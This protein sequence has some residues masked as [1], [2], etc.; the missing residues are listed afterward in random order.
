MNSRVS[1]TTLPILACLA[2]CGGTSPSNSSNPPGQTPAQAKSELA[3][4]P[5][6]AVPQADLQAAVAANNAFAVDLY[7]HVLKTA[8]AGNLFTSPISASL[9]LT[10]TY[11]GAKGQTASQMA[12][13]LH[14]GSATSTTFA[15]QNALDQALESRA[16]AALASDTQTAKNNQEPAPSASDYDLHVVNSVWGEQNYPWA[17][18]FL[19]VMATD[20]GAGVYLEDFVHAADQARQTINGWVSTQTADRI[21]NLL[22]P[23]SVDDTTRMVL[24]NAIHLKLPWASPFQASQTQNASFTRADG[25]TVSVPMMNQGFEGAGYADDGKAQILSVPLAGGAE[26]VIIALPHGDLASY[27]AQLSAGSAAL[28]PSGGSSVDVELSLPRVSFTSP[29]FSLAKALQ[30]MGM[31]D[32]FDSSAADFSGLCPNPPDGRLY[33]S[34]VLQKAMLGMKETGVEAAAAT[35]VLVNA[36]AA[37]GQ[38]IVMNVNRPFLVSIVDA[39]TGAVLFLGHVEDPSQT[40]E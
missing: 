16:A 11:A 25:T 32:A 37:P 13:A 40:G 34:D 24:V 21:N 6:S 26:N 36:G 3:R 14:L 23:G 4:T 30:A 12:A 28:Q 1:L 10:M 38:P 22:P 39:P 5:A 18:S 29:T 8:P 33:V 20:Y 35:A 27:E 2:A 17:S 19:D 15:G 31:V 7:A 9:A